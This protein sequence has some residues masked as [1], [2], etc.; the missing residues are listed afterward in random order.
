MLQNF[1]LILTMLVIITGTVCLI[2]MLFFAQSR[3]IKN[4]P[5]ASMLVRSA[6]DFFPVLLLVLVI[7]SFIIQP[8][9]VPS[10]S[11]EPTIL[12]NEFLLVNQFAYGLRL[13]V[14]NTKIIANSEPKTGDIVVFRNPEEPSINLIK[15]VIGLPGDHVIY[16][17]KVLYING[18]KADQT[19]LSSSMDI[20]P[21]QNISVNQYQENLNGVKHDIFINPNGGETN[22]YDII[23]PKNAYFMMGDN[24]DNSADSREW[25]F[26]PEANIIGKAF[27]IWM[28]WDAVNHTIRWN[29]I[30]TIL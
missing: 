9:H 6:R 25:G 21:G 27:I 19:L 12:P 29:R 24:R 14:L 8:F 20:E 7:R 15:R 23:V 28:S 22:N 10:G 17:N 13:P 30:G 11:L 26:A 18:K 1:T 2:D 3:T 4:T 16:Q 5:K